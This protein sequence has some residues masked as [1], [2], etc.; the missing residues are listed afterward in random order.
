MF[1][2]LFILT[3]NGFVLPAASPDHPEKAYPSAGVAV[4]KT[5]VFSFWVSLGSFTVPPSEAETTKVKV[6]V[7]SGVGTTASGIEL[8]LEQD[9]TIK[10]TNVINYLIIKYSMYEYKE[11]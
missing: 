1:L 5:L 10:K 6:T 3:L 11:T 7:G 4:N 2:L 8:Y 9:K